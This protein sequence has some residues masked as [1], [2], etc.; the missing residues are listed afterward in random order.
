MS[1]AANLDLSLLTYFKAT[2]VVE[3]KLFVSAPAPAGSDFQKV[4]APAPASAPEPAPAPTLALTYLL[5]QI[6]YFK[7]GFFIFL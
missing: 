1:L 2:S 4:S 3:P 5:S 6:S 7:S